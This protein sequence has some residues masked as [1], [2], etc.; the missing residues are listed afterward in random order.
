MPFESPEVGA[1]TARDSPRDDL[2]GLSGRIVSH[3]HVLEPLG[4]GGM[5]VVYRA[6]DTRLGRAVALKF[7]L[8][9]YDLD[10]SA[11][12]RFL[13]EARSAA[14]LDHPNLCTVYEAGETSDGQLYLAMALYAGETL[15]T[16]LARDGRLEAREAVA[17]AR[18]VADGLAYAH[19]AGIVHRDLK[20]GNLML[21]PDG[22]VKVLDFGLAK[23][24]GRTLTR[25]GAQLGTAAYMAPEQICGEAV[26]G[27]TDLWALGVVMFE[28]LTGRR[29]FEGDQDITLA[30]AIV[31]MTPTRPSA[32]C[33]GLPPGVEDVVLRLLEKE[34][35]SRYATAAEVAGDLNSM[36]LAVRT[37]PG[38]PNEQLP[39]RRAGRRWWRATL[40]S[41]TRTR[42]ALG[43]AALVVASGLTWYARQ[44]AR[45]AE[46]PLERSIAVLP[47]DNLGSAED[48]AYL[49]GGL[50]DAVITALTK[51][52]DL[53]VIS[54]QSVRAYAG[55][56]KSARDIGQELKVGRILQASVQRA[57]DSVRVG[58]HLVDARSD[59]DLW[60]NQYE[61]AAT[62][63]FA[64]ENDIAL[65]IVAALQAE[66][67]SSERRSLTRSPTRSA[68][69]YTFYLQGREY[70]QRPTGR[71]TYV[72]ALTERELRAAESLYR[73]A[74]AAD[75]NFALAH[76]QLAV[77]YSD[78][79]DRAQTRAEAETALRL[80]PDLP[81]GHLAMGR[82]WEIAGDRARA[83][84]EY[85]IAGRGMPN[86]GP[87]AVRIALIRRRQGRWQEALAGFEHAASV[88]PRASANSMFLAM[89]YGA[90][91]RYAESVRTWDYAIA[92]APDNYRYVVERARVLVTWQERPDSL[93]ATLR[94]LP[95][96]FD[97]EAQ[98]TIAR[99]DLAR[100]RRRPADGLAALA[101]MRPEFFD[102]DDRDVAGWLRL[103]RAWMYETLGDSGYARASFDTARA[104]FGAMVEKDPKAAHVYSDLGLAYAGLG[105]REE[106]VRA[107]RRSMEP[108]PLVDAYNAPVTMDHVAEIYMRVGET[109]AALDVLEQLSTIPNWVGLGFPAQLRFDPRWDRLRPNAR[110][111][112]LVQRQ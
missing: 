38:T 65:A 99:V 48:N 80:E 17:I 92:I 90:M 25:S 23:T 7:L 19:A 79:W 60:A 66:L 76:A 46:I 27:R 54:Q 95:R 83:L 49:A 108:Q 4:A 15:G 39:W 97:P 34:P 44:R 70:Q 102:S 2:L 11:K 62:D 110:F 98:T 1:H 37:P 87:V 14:T 91:R 106:A 61:R 107:A 82:Y 96:D 55:S 18:Q 111:Q 45:T 89:T 86:D 31:D 104:I 20:P 50:Q 12:E 53:R 26:D 77:V 64:L 52:T 29:P 69:A 63:L 59:K 84:A 24:K 58:A 47:F 42:V 73:R 74:L 88:D 103:C 13:L 8:P 30:R 67:P 10:D 33:P 43:A 100:L 41:T 72:V 101:A 57:G 28:M 21:L 105:Q 56:T 75:S 71:G 68:E 16:R 94:R 3:F 9:Q 22:T 32:L 6:E 51:V 93:E 81:E 85:E 40:W 5:G 78:L 35:S 112:R 36:P 109:D